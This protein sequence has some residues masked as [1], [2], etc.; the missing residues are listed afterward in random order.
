MN[1]I[2]VWL[3]EDKAVSMDKTAQE[4]ML[5]LLDLRNQLARGMTRLSAK[6]ERRAIVKKAM[7]DLDSA[8]AALHKL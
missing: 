8:R 4:G 6:D 2:R 3:T 7:R 1:P 5:V